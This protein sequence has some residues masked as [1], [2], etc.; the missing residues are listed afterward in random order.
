MGI[1]M[2]KDEEKI[3]GRK[4]DVDKLPYDLYPSEALEG[5]IRVLQFGAKKY[6]AR[7]WENGMRWGRLF[8]ALMR[9]L[10]AWWRGENL[11]QETGLS[12]LHHAACCI[13]FLQT[14]AIRN[15]GEDDRPSSVKK[16]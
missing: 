8:A 13:A 7:N 9:H 11:D 6:S 16:G 2:N 4:H 1:T 10:W 15:I 14:Y 12:H 3:E 5:T